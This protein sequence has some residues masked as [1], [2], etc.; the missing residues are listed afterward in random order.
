MDRVQ[1]R[2]RAEQLALAFLDSDFKSAGE[3]RVRV[4]VAR[5]QL[6]WHGLVSLSSEYGPEDEHPG[7]LAL[8]AGRVLDA[9]GAGGSDYGDGD[10]VD[11]EVGWRWTIDKRGW[12]AAFGINAAY[13]DVDE[14]SGARDVTTEALRGALLFGLHW[15][16]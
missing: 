8:G 10:Y 5:V 2:E 7:Y 9:R 3:R 1:E 14:D 11:L 6:R 16:A 15:G 12:V 13:V 4:E